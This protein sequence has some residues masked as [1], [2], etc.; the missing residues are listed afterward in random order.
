ME[1]SDLPFLSARRNNARRRRANRNS[2]MSPIKMSPRMSERDTGKLVPSFPNIPTCDHTFLIE[3][4]NTR[5]LRSIS[6]VESLAS[7]SNR[8]LL[9]KKFLLRRK[10]RSVGRSCNRKR[11]NFPR[12]RARAR[13]HADGSYLAS[14]VETK[15]NE[16]AG[17]NGR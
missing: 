3:Y 10:F 12:R 13:M 14:R 15:T 17:V 8:F 11:S 7:P 4:S 1:P 5:A 6:F 16:G 2:R 9:G